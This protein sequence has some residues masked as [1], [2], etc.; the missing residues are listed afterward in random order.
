MGFDLELVVGLALGFLLGWLVE[1]LID[2]VYWRRGDERAN[3]QLVLLEAEVG[4]LQAELDAMRLKL[5]ELSKRQTRLEA[6]PP[7][8]RE[9][10]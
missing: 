1:W 9:G 3:R 5:R 6:E 7:R 10:A 2:R 4:R 8:P